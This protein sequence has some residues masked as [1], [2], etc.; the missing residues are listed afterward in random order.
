[1]LL[2]PDC[3]PCIHKALLS[4]I[5]ELTSDDEQIKA[6]LSQVMQL[7]SLRDP[8][9]NLTSPHVLEAGLAKICQFFGTSDPFQALKERQNA[10][11]MELYSWLKSLVEESKDRLS[12]AAHLAIIG[13]SLDVMWSGG[14]MDVEPLIQQQLRN[15]LLSESFVHLEQRLRN[16]RLVLILGDNCGEIVFDRLFVETVKS[17]FDLQV[18]FAVRS[19]PTLNDATAKDATFVEMDK[20]ASIVDNG[21]DGPVPGTVVARCSDQMKRHIEDADLILSKGGGNF[22]S[23][24]EEVHL[25]HKIV[26]MLMSKCVPLCN[27]FGSKLYDPILSAPRRDG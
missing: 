5:R 18:V 9:W 22:D 21:I 11:A 4:A 20:I 12:T 10:R 26:F 6:L 16:S 15:P 14:S 3:V 19:V 24:E 27:Y 23:I 25:H 2:Q 13:N 1:M 8:A 17:I 7:P